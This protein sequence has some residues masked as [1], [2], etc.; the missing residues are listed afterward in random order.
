MARYWLQEGKRMLSYILIAS[1]TKFI[2]AVVRET[3]IFEPAKCQSKRKIDDN[4][5][6]VQ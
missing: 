4:H 1:P 2:A 6:Y 5:R 3:S